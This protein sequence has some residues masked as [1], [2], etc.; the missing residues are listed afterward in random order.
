MDSNAP[1]ANPP[2][3]SRSTVSP[4]GEVGLVDLL[5]PEM[6]AASLGPLGVPLRFASDLA[7]P[8]RAAPVVA[9]VQVIDTAP[10]AP[11]IDAPAAVP[12]TVIPS[13]S[14][15][16]ELAPVDIAEADDVDAPTNVYER[17]ARVTSLAATCQCAFS[18]P[19]FSSC[20]PLSLV[21]S[22]SSDCP[23]TGGQVYLQSVVL[24]DLLRFPVS[25]RF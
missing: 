2:P 18:P 7:S 15:P 21:T 13:L 11:A 6:H 10:V 23:F 20:V 25:K 1:P 8:V 16:V 12:D 4:P 3:V 19:L 14:D 24:K 9:Q 5:S 17:L 22:S